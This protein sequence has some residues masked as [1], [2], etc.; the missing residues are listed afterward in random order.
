VVSR[1]EVQ[2]E[3]HCSLRLLVA[4]QGDGVGVLD[5]EGAGGDDAGDAEADGGAAQAMALGHLLLDPQH[6]VGHAAHGGLVARGGGDAVAMEKAAI[7]GEGGDLGLGAAE[8]DADAEVV[9]RAH[10]RMVRRCGVWLKA[11]GGMCGGRKGGDDEGW[12]AARCGVGSEAEGTAKSVV[13]DC[14]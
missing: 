8:V 9:G 3:T 14:G 4:V 7:G 6:H 1:E 13:Q 2:C 5:H 11:G 10:G 12:S